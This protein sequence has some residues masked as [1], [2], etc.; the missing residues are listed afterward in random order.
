M[1]EIIIGEKYRKKLEIPLILAGFSPIFLPKNPDIDP[2]LDSHADLSMF[3]HKNTVILAPYLKRNWIVNYLTNRGF[4]VKISTSKQSP[5]YPGDVELCALLVG[6]RIIH[7]FNFTNELIKNISGLR[8][9]H[10]RQ[11]Y[12][13]CTAL[14]VKNALITSDKGIYKAAIEAGIET[15]LIGNKGIL[16][17][18]FDEGFIGG[19]CFEAK[20]KIYFTGDISKHPDY[21]NIVNFIRAHGMDYICLTD[22]PLFDI[23]GAVYL[24]QLF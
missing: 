4:E 9:V 20:G 6:E 3:I 19:C 7:N 2:K 5:I 8:K 18:G 10:V 21:L 15:L 11:G 22:D 1:N 16:L 14:A 13:R 17:E 24:A 23:G 12:C